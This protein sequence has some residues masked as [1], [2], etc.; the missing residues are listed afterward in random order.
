MRVYLYLDHLCYT[1][2]LN[3]SKI[4]KVFQDYDKVVVEDEKDMP[5]FVWLK[6]EGVTLDKVGIKLEFLEAK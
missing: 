2:P 3:A 6:D 1:S 5:V 4:V